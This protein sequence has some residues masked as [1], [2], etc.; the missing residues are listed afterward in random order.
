MNVT[1]EA[2]INTR[3][4]IGDVILY[5]SSNNPYSSSD[6]GSRLSEMMNYWPQNYDSVER[7]LAASLMGMSGMAYVNVLCND[8]RGYSS[9]G[10]TG[11]A[12]A[13]IHG[14]T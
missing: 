7:A 10:V 13:D 14:G 5:T 6:P 4:L 12:S 3:L 11:V 2:E 1:Y 9:S 8:S